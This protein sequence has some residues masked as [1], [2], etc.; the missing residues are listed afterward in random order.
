[1]L[2]NDGSIMCCCETLSLSWR[3]EENNTD[4]GFGWLYTSRGHG[5]YIK[6]VVFPHLVF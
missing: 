4:K 3:G 2:W 1:M 5:E 6:L